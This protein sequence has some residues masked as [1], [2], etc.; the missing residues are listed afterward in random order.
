[1]NTLPS[2]HAAGALAV[3]LAVSTAMPAAG[4]GLSVIAIGI[5]LA[6]VFGRYH[7]AI[8]SILGVGVAIAAWLAGGA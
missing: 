2:A 5:T 1:V 6:T 7:Y 3:G 8:D 4:L